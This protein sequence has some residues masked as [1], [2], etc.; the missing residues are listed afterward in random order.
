MFVYG[1]PKQN[2]YITGG[3]FDMNTPLANRIYVMDFRNVKNFAMR[4]V[5]FNGSP[6]HTTTRPDQFL[7]LM[8]DSFLVEDCLFEKQKP[9]SNGAKFYSWY[10]SGTNGV[11]H[12]NR[13]DSSFTADG[14]ENTFVSSG[15]GLYHNT[16]ISGGLG[17]HGNASDIEIAYNVIDVFAS[18]NNAVAIRWQNGRYHHNYMIS[19]NPTNYASY[20]PFVFWENA[21]RHVLADNNWFVC[22]GGTAGSNTIAWQSTLYGPFSGVIF[23][24]NKIWGAR[25]QSQTNPTSGYNFRDL[26]WQRVTLYK[27]L[28]GTPYYS[29]TS[30]ATCTIVDVNVL[31]TGILT[32]PD[33]GTVITCPYDGGIVEGP[34]PPVDPPT[35]NP[36]VDECDTCVYRLVRF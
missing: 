25:M 29:P 27:Y 28:N 35:E 19:H 20:K 2:I 33:P 26:T 15:I 22:L 5:A 1:N 23:R 36:P 32:P 24:D 30:C 9:D 17:L 16:V 21:Y 7:H 14:A 18:P 12:R 3:R 11:M 34:P 31:T 10:V 4:N 13:V 8:A 6:G